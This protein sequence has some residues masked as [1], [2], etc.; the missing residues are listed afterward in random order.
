MELF[1]V[2]GILVIL[3]AFIIGVIF[4]GMALF[5]SRRVIFNRQIRIAERKATKMMTEATSGS[6]NVL[7]QA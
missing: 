5:L 2:Q 1:G 7:T 3:F 4:G 6:Q